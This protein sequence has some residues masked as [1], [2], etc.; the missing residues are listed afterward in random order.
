MELNF[1]KYFVSVA[2]YLNFSE[3]ARRNYVSQSTVSRGIK[4]LE[5]E[6]GTKLFSRTKRDVVLTTEGKALLP[7]AVDI[8]ERM[9]SANFLIEKLR[10]GVDGKITLGYDETIGTAISRYIKAFAVKYPEISIDIKKIKT[11][12]EILGLDNG[13]IDVVF[14]PADLLPDSGEIEQR[15]IF[16]DSLCVICEKGLIKERAVNPEIFHEQGIVLLSEGESPILYMEIFDLLRTYNIVPGV[17]NRF[18]SITSLII[19]VCAGLGVSILPASLCSSLKS[20]G[21]DIH[22]IS[23]IETGISYVM[24]WNKTIS[25]PGTKLFIKEM[26]TV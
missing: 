12:D 11:S 3:A 17:I 6:L 25:N 20:S 4:E 9:D 22:P 23:G 21:F 26:Q 1:I 18:E 13:D 8:V 2:Q 10:R 5:K 19:A 14:L 16:D 24:A 15:H 7:Y